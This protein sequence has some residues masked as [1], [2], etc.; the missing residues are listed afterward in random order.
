MKGR[1]FF[2]KALLIGLICKFSTT[3]YLL[4]E[5]DGSSGK[6]EIG[7]IFDCMLFDKTFYHYIYYKKP[8]LMHSKD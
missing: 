7:N 3:K 2:I 6:D 4:V 5:V 1:S 8:Y